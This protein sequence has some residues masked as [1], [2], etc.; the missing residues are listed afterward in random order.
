MTL[1]DAWA[2][3]EAALPEGWRFL[4]L[5]PQYGDPREADFDKWTLCWTA[6]ATDEPLHEMPGYAGLDHPDADRSHSASGYGPTPADALL[7]LAA[8]LTAR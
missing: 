4:D 7:D 3:A 1:D 2:K 5:C 8:S 6:M